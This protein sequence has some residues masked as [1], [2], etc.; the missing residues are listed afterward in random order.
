MT[1][2]NGDAMQMLCDEPDRQLHASADRTNVLIVCSGRFNECQVLIVSGMQQIN[3]PLAG[4]P[5]FQK[6]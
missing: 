1:V 3:K 6:P 5:S 2:T 4:M